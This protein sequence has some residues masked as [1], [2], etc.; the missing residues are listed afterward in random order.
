V[1][2]IHKM[3]TTEKQPFFRCEKQW[4]NGM[5]AFV[6]GAVLIIAMMF[7][8][9]MICFNAYGI[10]S[11]ESDTLKDLGKAALMDWVYILISSVVTFGI[12][13]GLS[14]SNCISNKAN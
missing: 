1:V 10:V 11:A 6:S 3:A 13:I 9:V 2:D 7:S 8:I 4:I 14:M 5:F 12:G